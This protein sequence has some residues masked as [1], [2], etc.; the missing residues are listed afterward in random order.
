MKTYNQIS[1]KTK[2]TIQGWYN[3]DK[4][5]L[6]WFENEAEWSCR[7][8]KVS[9]EYPNVWYDEVHRS[10]TTNKSFIIKTTYILGIITLVELFV[11]KNAGCSTILWIL[12][13]FY[14]LEN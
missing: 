6:F 9:E 4:G 12:Y 1:A 5:E 8:D 13:G 7:E 3:T 10:Q 11:S 2:P 14:K